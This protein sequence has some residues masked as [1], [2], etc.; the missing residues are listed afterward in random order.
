MDEKIENKK[1][2]II[3][4]IK[5][6]EDMWILGVIHKFIAGMAREED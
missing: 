2:E 5:S 1:K 6:I 4:T 3:E